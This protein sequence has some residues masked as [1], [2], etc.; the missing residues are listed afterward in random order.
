MELTKEQQA[1]ALKRLRA[2]WLD[3]RCE[4]CRADDWII[5]E[6]IY[7]VRP[8]IPG[9]LAVGGR[10]VPLLVLQCDRCGNTRFVNPYVSGAVKTPPYCGM[11]ISD[12]DAPPPRPPLN[13]P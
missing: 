11:G 3:P 5:S 6:R 9:E 7:D 13:R 12:V 2:L 1:T 4:A 10:Y 8:H